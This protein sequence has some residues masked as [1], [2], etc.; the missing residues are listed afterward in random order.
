MTRA[1]LEDFDGKSFY[2]ICR[3]WTMQRLLH[4]SDPWLHAIK[5]LRRAV[6]YG[7]NQSDQDSFQLPMRVLSRQTT[8]RHENII[9]KVLDRPTSS[10]AT[11]S[12][13][14]ST[15]CHY[16]DQLWSR[17]IA[18]FNGVCALT[19]KPVRKGDLVYQPRTSGHRPINA[20]R[21]ILS[22]VITLANSSE[23]LQM[24]AAIDSS[25]AECAP[26]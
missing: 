6:A 2:F 3:G 8:G 16:G 20:N 19:G 14:D 9:V 22:S 4:T 1:Q 13:R 10:T 25:V 23:I 7:I 26:A 15:S 24:P 5:M 11:V 18:R 17:R 21:M 12:W